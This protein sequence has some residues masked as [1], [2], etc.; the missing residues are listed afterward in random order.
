MQEW[1]VAVDNASFDE[2][3]ITKDAQGAVIEYIWNGLEASANEIP[4]PF[5]ERIYQ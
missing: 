2:A 3:G 4:S 5:L 1:S